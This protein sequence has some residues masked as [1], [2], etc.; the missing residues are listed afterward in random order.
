MALAILT[1][2]DVAV[3][4]LGETPTQ[5]EPRQP[6]QVSHEDDGVTMYWYGKK[7]IHSGHFI[8]GRASVENFWFADGHKM[9]DAEM[10]KFLQPYRTLK[11]SKWTIVADGLA[12]CELSQNGTVLAMAWYI[13]EKQTL[14]LMNM[15]SYDRMMSLAQH[16]TAEQQKT[17]PSV[18][19]EKRPAP[20]PQ[21]A[22]KSSDRMLN[23][24]CAIVATENLHRLAANAAWSAT[25][26][27]DVYE[28]GKFVSGH[29]VAVWKI[30]TDSKVWAVDQNGTL[31]IETTSTDVKDILMALGAKYSTIANKT[32]TLRDGYIT[33]ASMAKKTAEY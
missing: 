12:M 17:L 9:T 21:T 23:K 32:V 28:D 10:A 22:S 19:V 1:A 30:A 27:F 2:S 3:A 16:E 20:R 26:S 31:Q 15:S 8:Q 14:S 33:A 24:D 13:L 11:F 29:A 18:A 5:F 25:L 7:V 6:D 4:A